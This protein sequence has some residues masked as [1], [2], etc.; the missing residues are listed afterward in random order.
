MRNFKNFKTAHFFMA[1]LFAGF[2]FFASCSNDDFVQ[3]DETTKAARNFQNAQDIKSAGNLP[4]ALP[5]CPE[6]LTNDGCN[7]TSGSGIDQQNFYT[8]IS[9]LNNCRTE[10]LPAGCSL[11]DTTTRIIVANLNG[12]CNSA[13]ALNA[14]MN[15]WKQL[16]M[17]VRPGSDYIITG[18]QLIRYYSVSSYDYRLDIN[19]TY[20]K[21]TCPLTENPGIPI[22]VINF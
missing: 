19:V 5:G 4:A 12:C 16:A 14:Q 3:H 18:Y 6:N 20:R 17:N 21:K 2:V 22:R 8:M 15:A 7:F 13:S 1:A 11:S 9:L 10:A